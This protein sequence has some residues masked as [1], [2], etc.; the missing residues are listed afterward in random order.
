MS[1]ATTASVPDI[2]RVPRVGICV[3]VVKDGKI[4]LG[5]RKGAHG[6]GEYASPGGHL[7]HLERVAECAAREVREETGLEIGGIRFLRAL[8]MMQY[9]P[10]HYIDL[11]FA[12]D[13]VSGEPEVREPDK[14]ESWAWYDFEALPSPLFSA[15][16]TAFAAL[17]DGSQQ[18]WDSP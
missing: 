13:W 12:A 11:A 8:N 5:K 1:D 3:I 17:R 6:A 18:W 2:W 9:A 4:L 10:R 16:P 15:L 14:V 7:E